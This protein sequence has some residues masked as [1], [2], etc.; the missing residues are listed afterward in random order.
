MPF[1]ALV[2]A[3][4]ADELEAGLTGGQIQRIIQPS[5]YSVALSIY[6]NG[7]GHW[8]LLSA[9]AGNARV[10]LG[11]DR[12]AKAFPTPSGFVMALRKHLEGGRVRGVVQAAYERVLRIECSHGETST[13]L[14]AEVMGKHSNVMLIDPAE[15]ILGAMK[16]VP[17][18]QSRVRPILPGRHYSPPPTQPRD[19][20]LY[21]EGPR[22]DPAQDREA[23]VAALATAPE[24]TPVRAA[25]LGLLPGAGPFLC[26]QI[27]L[28]AGVEAATLVHATDGQALA[29]HAASF[30]RLLL[31]R[32][33]EPVTFTN[34]RGRTDFAPFAPHGALDVVRRESIGEAVEIALSAGESRDPLSQVRR[35]V[36]EEVA[37]AQRAVIGRLHSLEEGLSSSADAHTVMEQGQLVL[38][39]AYSLER[40]ATELDLPEYGVRVALNPRLSPSENAERLFRRYRKLRDAAARLPTMIAAAA[41]ERERLEELE[42][43]VDLASTEPDL[44]SV[45]AELRT[46]SSHSD[47]KAPKRRE[48]RKGPPRYRL[49]G[50]TVTAGRTALENEEVTFHLAGRDDLWLHARERTGAHVVVHGG[51]KGLPNTELVAA[52]ALAAYFSEGRQD[53]AVDVDVAVVRDVRKIPGGPPGRVTYRNSETVRVA[54]SIDGWT[55]LGGQ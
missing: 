44:L 32:A 37:R 27:A 42:R 16:V 45:K 14:I 26:D 17:P 54:P 13:A 12:L 28:A 49:N 19:A 30:L 11:S 40:G 35:S 21:G 10:H 55:R 8:L 20:A 50:W 22:I 53:T 5:L 46:D 6:A 24:D 41:V 31:T 23:F 38:A 43:F 3:A 18:H 39:Y 33:W 47:E 48:K 15:T 25:L 2:M 34:T 52:A 1:D 7:K 29:A 36:R 51:A 4:T 9:D